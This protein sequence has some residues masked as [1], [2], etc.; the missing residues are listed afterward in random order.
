M[1]AQTVYSTRGMVVAGQP[2]A[3]AA[4]ANVLAQGGNAVDGALAV[5][6]ATAVTRPEMCGRG[7]D[8]FALVYDAASRRVTAY[9]GSGPA[10]ASA[11][12][13]AFAERGFTEL[14]PFD[15]WLSVAPPGAVSVY[16]GLHRD[17]ATRPLRQ[18]W[19]DAIRLADEG[20]PLDARCATYLA[21]DARRLSGDKA[22]ARLLLPEGRP[23]PVGAVLRNHELARSLE[24]VADD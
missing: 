10:P 5:A 1:H 2:L 8:A 11:T 3:T 20:F 21:A 4:G 14:M 18:L 15:G 6:G 24:A 22:A 17:H 9:N 16:A 12:V 23:L 7:G 13:E 19:T